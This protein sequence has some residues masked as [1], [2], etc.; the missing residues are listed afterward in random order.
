MEVIGTS[1]KSSHSDSP[2]VK[3]TIFNMIMLM[4]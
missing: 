4:M 1:F 3:E 2:K